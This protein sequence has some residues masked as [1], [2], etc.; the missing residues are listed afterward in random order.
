[1]P[2]LR[3]RKGYRLLAL[4][5]LRGDRPVERAWL[6]G[7]LW[8]DHSELRAFANLRESLKDLRRALG[9]A[10]ARLRSATARTLFLDL[11]SV[12]CDMI[13]F[14]RVIAR[15]ETASLEAAVSLY[16]GALLE[17]WAEEWVF[18]ERLVREQAFVTALQTLAADAVARGEPV[19]AVGYL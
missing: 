9:S 2:R 4:L 13:S 17:G 7:V 10:A 5:V 12:E 8:P 16:R 14:D 3:S 11:T 18:Q 1:L 15:G 19:E 6:A